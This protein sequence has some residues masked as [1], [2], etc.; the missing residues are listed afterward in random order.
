MLTDSPSCFPETM[1][2]FLTPFPRF[3]W[4]ILATVIVLPLGIVGASYFYTTLTNFTS[5][6]GYWA[7][8]YNAVILTEHIV[9]RRCRFETYDRSA[10]NDWRKLPPGFAPMAAAILTLGLLI[11]CVDQVWFSGPLAELSGDLGFE[12]GLVLCAL[13]YVPLR[14]VEKH[15]AKR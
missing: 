11:P 9:I 13:L 6:L 3:I 10:W 1:L 8:L 4:P 7:A 15:F 2:P 14:L 5:V 12:V